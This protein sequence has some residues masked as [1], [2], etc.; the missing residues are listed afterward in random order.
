M[1]KFYTFIIYNNKAYSGGGI[2]A[3][4]ESN[5]NMKNTIICHIVYSLIDLVC[6]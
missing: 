5:T 1:R 4:G 2:Y 6:H 3:Y